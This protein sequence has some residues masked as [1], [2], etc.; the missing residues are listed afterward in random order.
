MFM[1][2]YPG[3]TSPQPPLYAHFE[4]AKSSYEVGE[5]V[6]VACNFSAGATAWEWNKESV[7]CPSGSSPGPGSLSSGIRLLSV[8]TTFSNIPIF[9]SVFRATICKLRIM[10]S[11]RTAVVKMN[12]KFPNIRAVEIVDK[13]WAAGRQLPNTFVIK[14]Q[15]QY[16][17]KMNKI[18]GHFPISHFRNVFKSLDVSFSEA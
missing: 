9:M 14:Y 17:K 3:I 2:I 1:K 6:W 16:I 10:L 13:Q 15:I 18:N 8:L 5:T 11:L 4:D 7:Y 12:V